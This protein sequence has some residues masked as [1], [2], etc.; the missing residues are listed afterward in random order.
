M[1]ISTDAA[2]SIIVGV[3]VTRLA[4][5]AINLSMR[6]NARKAYGQTPA[7]VLVDGGYTMKSSNIK[8]W[9]SKE[10]I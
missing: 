8:R 7:Q 1:Q 10:S 2:H 6:S 9:Q 3:E 5:T 4:M